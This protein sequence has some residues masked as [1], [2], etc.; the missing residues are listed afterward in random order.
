[1]S[2]RRASSNAVTS[3]AIADAMDG[4]EPLALVAP[5]RFHGPSA[6]KGKLAMDAK[7]ASEAA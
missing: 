2:G 3:L 7:E 5:M 4:P 6:F 1:M